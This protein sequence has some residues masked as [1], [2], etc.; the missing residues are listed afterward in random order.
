MRDPSHTRALPVEELSGLFTAAGWP[1]LQVERTR[2]GLDLDN[3]LARSYPQEGD[4]ARIRAL[5]DS[6]L[7]DDSLDLE[8]RR[9]QKMI[10]FSVP[11]AILSAQ[12]PHLL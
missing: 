5:F 9:E 12:V 4:E 8:P 7:T 10:R 2:L 6:A 1:A 11:I 3:F